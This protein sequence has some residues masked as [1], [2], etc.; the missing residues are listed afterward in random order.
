MRISD[1]SSDVCSSDLPSI[2]PIPQPSSDPLVQPAIGEGFI[3]GPRLAEFDVARAL[4]RI[5]RAHQHA[6]ARL[7]PHPQQR[8]QCAER[9]RTDAAVHRKIGPVAPV[10]VK[11]IE[12]TLQKAHGNGRA[13]VDA[14]VEKLLGHHRSEEHKSELQS[15]MRN[16][17][18]VFCLTKKHTNYIPLLILPTMHINT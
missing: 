16:S 3:G 12:R 7:S 17:Y 6:R 2:M 10:A 1:W 4:K 13:H 11:R 15:L 14:G 8:P 9:R 18:A 5:H